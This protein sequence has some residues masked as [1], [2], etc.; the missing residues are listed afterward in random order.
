MKKT[1]DPFKPEDYTLADQMFLQA[2][3]DNLAEE[4]NVAA[5]K[6][7]FYVDA[8]KAFKDGK[9]ITVVEKLIADHLWQRVNNKAQ[10]TTRR[11]LRELDSGQLSIPVDSWMHQVVTVGK[12]RRS[13]VG[14][15]GQSDVLRM[16][17]ARQENSD[18][19]DKMRDFA[20]RVAK[21][22]EPVWAQASN[23]DEAFTKHLIALQ[24]T[25]VPE[26]DDDEASA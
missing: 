24:V 16:V 19:A 1:S 2:T 25:T 14:N 22:L 21:K 5:I 7:A 12:H 10:G 23:L 18:K 20:V 4:E 15:L 6:T 17:Q 8:G 26:S 13:T 11:V 9:F 3:V